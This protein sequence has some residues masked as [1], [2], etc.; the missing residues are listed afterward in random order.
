M[1]ERGL[2][3]NG[4]LLVLTLPIGGLNQDKMGT[5]SLL[6]HTGKSPQQGVN[7]ASS[8]TPSPRGTHAD[9]DRSLPCFAWHRC[10]LVPDIVM[11]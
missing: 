10:V 9:I 11:G 5:P 7:V 8:S 4:E 2:C 3:A 6:T 1:V